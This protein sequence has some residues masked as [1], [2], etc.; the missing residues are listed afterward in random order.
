M[1][2]RDK[3]FILNTLAMLCGFLV[4]VEGWQALDKGSLG[5]GI[6]AIILGLAAILNSVNKQ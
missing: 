5:Y 4:V 3:Q 1:K 6:V 2:L